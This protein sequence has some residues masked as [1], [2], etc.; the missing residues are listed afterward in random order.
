MEKSIS[1]LWVDY[2]K[3]NRIVSTNSDPSTGRL[4]YR[5]QVF[6][7]DL[8]SFLDLKCDLSS[9]VREQLVNEIVSNRSMASVPAP[10][11]SGF[12][13]DK[14]CPLT[15]ADVMNV[16]AN[17]D[18]LALQS[19]ENERTA[20]KQVKQADDIEH[21]KAVIRSDMDWSD[22]NMLASALKSQSA[23]QA[24]LNPAKVFSAF[25]L[26][27]PEPKPMGRL[28]RFFRTPQ[29]PTPDQ[30]EVEWQE[31]GFP[32]GEDSFLKFLTGKGFGVDQVRQALETP[33]DES[34]SEGPRF[35]ALLKLAEYVSR[36]FDKEGLADVV[37]YIESLPEEMDDDD[38]EYN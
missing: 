3:N 10:S 35:E 4:E 25:A 37:R 24:V 14:G 15:E 8:I 16:F 12:I 13:D 33:D 27:A 1:K 7:D 9:G 17:I 6:T 19:A 30:L 28:A 23:G 32:L 18:K 34:M 2:L 21:I 38:D 26:L 11:S 29:G 20:E 22:R 36:N 31:V 5:R